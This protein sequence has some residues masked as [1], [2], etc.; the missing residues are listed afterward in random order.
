MGENLP[1]VRADARVHFGGKVRYIDVGVTSPCAVDHQRGSANK[2]FFASSKYEKSKI[3]KYGK[4][5]NKTSMNYLVP[6]IMETTGA[7]GIAG[8]KFLKLLLN[9]L[10]VGL[11][12]E[13]AKNYWR[14]FRRQVAIIFS[15]ANSRAIR[16]GY[17]HHKVMTNEEINRI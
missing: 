9:N 17:R 6:F 14:T 12:K 3:E 2:S 5:L 16:V 15:R 13:E 8:N 10:D 1:D 7:I 11:S 4:V